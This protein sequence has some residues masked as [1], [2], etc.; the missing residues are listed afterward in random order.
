MPLFN[1]TTYARL[2]E[3]FGQDESLGLG[4]HAL[5]TIYGEGPLDLQPMRTLSDKFLIN[6]HHPGD[7][8]GPPF[9]TR[10]SGVFVFSLSVISAAALVF[11]QVRTPSARPVICRAHLSFDQT[12]P[13]QD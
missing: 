4:I 1:A 13:A 2:C 8:Q 10:L 3:D 12:I 7:S 11:H 9:G 6:G 5:A